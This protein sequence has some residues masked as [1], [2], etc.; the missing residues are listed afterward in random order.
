MGICG[1]YAGK[2]MGKRSRHDEQWE[3]LRSTIWV[4]ADV[5]GPTVAELEALGFKRST[6]YRAADRL[7][8][9]NEIKRVKI[10]GVLHFKLIAKSPLVTSPAQ[11]SILRILKSQTADSS[12]KL[13]AWRD[14]DDFSMEG[15]IISDPL[16]MFLL[17]PDQVRKERALRILTRQAIRAAN[18]FDNPTLAR[19]RTR[20]KQ[21]ETIVSDQKAEM[22]TRDAAFL[23]L[24]VLNPVRA[25]ALALDLISQKGRDDAL[26]S[27]P[28]TQLLLNLSATIIDAPASTINQLYKL[29]STKTLAGE[30]AKKLLQA[31]NQP[32]RTLHTTPSKHVSKDSSKSSTNPPNPTTRQ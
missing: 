13:Q 3:K 16:L 25:L 7:E 26:D 27:D 19:M 32:F 5:N 22:N 29:A 2:R 1:G 10:D 8:G 20:E 30:R 15:K 28:Q 12:V 21:A 17:Q 23:F 18:E 11:D 9:I 14:L 6:I 31:R 4:S 24:K